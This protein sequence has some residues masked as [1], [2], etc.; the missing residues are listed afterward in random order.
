MKCFT[1]AELLE[2]LREAYNAG[3]DRAHRSGHQSLVHREAYENDRNV[4]VLRIAR[5]DTG[6]YDGKGERT[7]G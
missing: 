7:D 6:G 3:F 4:A 2:K 5:A 1:E